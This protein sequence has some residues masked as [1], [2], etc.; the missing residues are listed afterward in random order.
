MKDE[1][2]KELRDDKIIKVEYMCGIRNPADLLTKVLPAYKHRGIL[3]IIQQIRT[4][5]D[6]NSNPD[7]NP[8]PNPEDT[9]SDPDPNINPNPNTDNSN[10]NF[11]SNPL[12]NNPNP[13][14][15]TNPNTNSST[16]TNSNT[17]ATS[18][19]P[20]PGPLVH[21]EGTNTG[22]GSQGKDEYK[23]ESVAKHWSIGVVHCP[24]SSRTADGRSR[25]C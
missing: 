12:Y 9:A 22:R 2:I 5:Q 16:N 7:P 4:P 6:T 25:N 15:N 21:L 18:P 23:E 24:G 19:S 17:G 11:Y 10:S 8:N 20:N 13:R 14:D 3:N 1:W